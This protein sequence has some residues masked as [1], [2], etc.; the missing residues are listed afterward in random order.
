MVVCV[1]VSIRSWNLGSAH[2]VSLSTEVYFYLEYGLELLFKQYEWLKK[3]LEVNDAASYQRLKEETASEPFVLSAFL[4]FYARAVFPFST[5]Y[6]PL[7]VPFHAKFVFVLI[8]PFHPVLA[9]RL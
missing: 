1:C 2:I 9:A 4:F 7:N 8:H 5:R 3:D 6:H